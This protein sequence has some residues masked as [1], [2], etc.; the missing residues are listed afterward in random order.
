MND[1][2]SA[3]KLAPRARRAPAFSAIGDIRR[4]ASAAAELLKA[5]ANSQRLSVLCALADG[6]KSVGAIN[7]R[8]PLSQSALSQH[9]AVL[10]ARALVTARRESQM[11]HYA[12]APGPALEIMKV[13]YSAYCAPRPRR[14]SPALTPS[15]ISRPRSRSSRVG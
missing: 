9:L 1:V 13:L 2:S 3:R 12:L 6:P 7:A 5:M 11:I 8:V 15:A 14:R 4:H 10:R